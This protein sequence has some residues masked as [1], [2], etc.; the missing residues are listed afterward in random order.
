MT[1]SPFCPSRSQALVALILL[2]IFM[3]ALAMSAQAEVRI[4]GESDAVKIDATE[5]SAEEL[6]TELGHAY[7]L[8]YRSSADLNRSISGTFTGSLQ[9]VVSRVLS[10]QGY[11]FGVETSA[12]GI[13]VAVYG[14]GSLHASNESAPKTVT[15]SSSQPPSSAA[16]GPP[17]RAQG[18][19]NADP[20]PAQ[21]INRM[22]SER[23]RRL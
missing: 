20:A 19:K 22:N 5:A 2:A 3:Q 6:L 4:T 23:A 16:D 21:R 11:D 14:K 9:E 18:Q 17:K 12:D 1:R 13:V 8:R 10:L 7:G 15:D